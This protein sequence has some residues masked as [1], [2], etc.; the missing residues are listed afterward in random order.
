VQ[1]LIWWTQGHIFVDDMRITDIGAYDAILGVNWLKQFSKTTNKWVDKNISFHY[2]GKDI[3]LQGLQS[4]PTTELSMLSVE[5]LHK[6][7]SG[8]EVWAVAIVDSLSTMISSDASQLSPDLQAL[9]TENQDVF[10]EPKHLP[11][12]RALDHAISLPEEAQPVNS[13]PYRYSPLQKDEIE[14]QVEEMLQAGVITTSMSPFASPMLL[15]KKKDGS[16]LGPS[17]FLSQIYEL[18]TIKSESSLKMRSKLLLKCTMDITSSESC[19][20]G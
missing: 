16:W 6:W 4:K 14:R 3:M 19:P 8:N 10:V 7:L 5:Q 9:L 15:V 12:Q 11:P 20:L 17:T 18:A 1:G 2:K 13:R